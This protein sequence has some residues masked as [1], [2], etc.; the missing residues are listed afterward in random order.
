MDRF[1]P[2]SFPI[3]TQ[4]TKRRKKGRQLRLSPQGPALF[5]AKSP[6]DQG[7]GERHVGIGLHG[8]QTRSGVHHQKAT[9]LNPLEPA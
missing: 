3:R 1:S 5:D 4:R 2:L 9:S 6:R 8:D 7:A